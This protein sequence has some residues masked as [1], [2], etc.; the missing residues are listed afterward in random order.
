MA[1]QPVRQVPFWGDIRVLV[2][3]PKR[4]QNPALRSHWIV[5]KL[6]EGEELGS[7]ILQVGQSN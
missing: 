1:S 6:A 5:P 7:N 4:G 3:R 2:V